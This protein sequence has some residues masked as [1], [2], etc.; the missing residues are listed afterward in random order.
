[1]TEVPGSNV[2]RVTTRTRTFV[3]VAVLPGE[4]PT[5]TLGKNIV[6]ALQFLLDSAAP[7]P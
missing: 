5:N 2:S 4:G 6:A 1:V 7:R 3:Q